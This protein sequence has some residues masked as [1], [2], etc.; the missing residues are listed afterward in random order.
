MAAVLRGQPISTET[1]AVVPHTPAKTPL[2]RKAYVVPVVA[3]NLQ[4]HSRRDDESK[5][6]GHPE[7]SHRG[8]PFSKIETDQF[9]AALEEFGAAAI[10][11]IAAAVPTRSV[12]VSNPSPVSRC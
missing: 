4:S 12:Y 3:T 8:G 6:I 5:S 11:K 2:K 10:D 1:E 9:N 7:R